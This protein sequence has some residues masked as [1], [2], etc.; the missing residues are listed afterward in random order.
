MER[1]LGAFLDAVIGREGE[2]PDLETSVMRFA[3]ALLALAA[4]GPPGR[5][6]PEMIGAVP[7][8]RLLDACLRS[9]VIRERF[10]ALLREAIGR[11]TTA[12]LA[13]QDSGRVRRDVDAEALATVLATLA[14]GVLASREVGLPMDLDLAGRTVAKLLA[15]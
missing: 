11:L 13:G 1:V 5:L 9:P 3:G 8:H 10:V 7:L 4:A 12:A 14:F 6:G 2:A 15:P